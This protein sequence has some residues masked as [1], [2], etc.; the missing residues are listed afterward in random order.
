MRKG[1]TLIELMIVIAIIAIIAAIAI[2]NLL[3]SRITANEAQAGANLKSGV[4]PGQVQF[5]AGGYIDVDADGIGTYAD[6]HQFMS[7]V[8]QAVPA[9][10]SAPVIALALLDDKWDVAD[11]VAIAAY[12]YALE[13]DALG[14]S[15]AILGVSNAEDNCE[16]FWAGYAAPAVFN[17]GGR[18][19]FGINTGGS[20][21]AS[22]GTVDMSAETV[23]TIAWLE[24][25]APTGVGVFLTDPE[26]GTAANDPLGFVPY[27]K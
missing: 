5:Q 20:I 17:D 3:E 14:A 15:A 25:I 1:F 16:R 18:R 11:G 12:A 6:E 27:Q 9:L 7:G 19:F 24:G 26:G 8:T 21:F 13:T 10:G 2:P 22:L 23:A 4:L